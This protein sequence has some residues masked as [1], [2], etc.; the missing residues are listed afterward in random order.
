MIKS[1]VDE[2]VQRRLDANRRELDEQRQLEAHLRAME[3]ER[4]AADTSAKP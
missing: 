4:L 3:K 1:V 2:E